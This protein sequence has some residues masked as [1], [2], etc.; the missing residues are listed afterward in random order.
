[1][2]VRGVSCSGLTE[3][4]VVRR[5]HNRSREVSGA[6]L[7]ALKRAAALCALLVSSSTGPALAQPAGDPVPPA[8]PAPTAAPAPAPPPAAE[9]TAPP[10]AQTDQPA[11]PPGNAQPAP[12]GAPPPGYGYPPP[13]YGYPPPGYY[14][15]P[16][17]GSPPPEPPEELPEP[18]DPNLLSKV[19]LVPRIGVMF[20]GSGTSRIRCDGYCLG[21]QDSSTSYDHHPAVVLDF[22]VLFRLG[23]VMRLGPG[24]SYTSKMKTDTEGA[25][26][27]DLGSEFGLNVVG[28]PAISVGTR[29]W[30]APRG[31]LGLIVLVPSGE[32]EQ[33]LD[34]MQ[35]LCYTGDSTSDCSSLDGPVPGFSG[36]IGAGGIFGVGERA[37]LR[38]DLMLRYYW[39]QLADFEEGTTY[40]RVRW[41]LSGVRAYVFLGGDFL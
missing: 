41:S 2:H 33:S 11:P 4:A 12:Y 35:D 18:P 38:A 27:V 10:P 17:P 37:R 5:M 20:W 19:A 25:D 39:L 26:D 36:G 8:E 16:P 13:G 7:P 15:Y 3:E 14:G 6:S 40:G 1:M 9:P 34:L 32:T 21:L 28:E 30:I 31:E 23:R 22:D 24:I 29:A